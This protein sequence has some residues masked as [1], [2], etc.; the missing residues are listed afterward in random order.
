MTSPVRHGGTV[1]VP[2]E[3]LLADDYEL[4][5]VWAPLH[6]T[7]AGGPECDAICH[8]GSEDDE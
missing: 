7:C 1:D 5:L 6:E 4:Q 2:V 8:C 3:A